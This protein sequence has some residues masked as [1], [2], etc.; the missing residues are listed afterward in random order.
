MDAYSIDLRERVLKAVEE[1]QGT[2]ESIAKRFCVTDRW[3]RKLVQQKRET[4]SIAP[5]P[6]GGGMPAKLSERQMERLRGLVAKDP[7]ATLSELHRRMRIS[8]CTMT[9]SRALG[10]LGFTHKKRRSEPLSKIAPT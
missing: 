7:D 1:E 8:C 2:R 4:G 6:H 3:M 10:R 5:K 9:I